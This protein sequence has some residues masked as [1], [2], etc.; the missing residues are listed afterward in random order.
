MGLG[1]KKWEGAYHIILLF[2]WLDT[3]YFYIDI[4]LTDADPG[5]WKGGGRG[6]WVINWQCAHRRLSHLSLF[7]TYILSIKGGGCA[8]HAP[9][10]QLSRGQEVGGEDLSFPNFPYICGCC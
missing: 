7:F 6:V 1:L 10:D 9:L 5:F 3:I 2:I 4:Q 8:P